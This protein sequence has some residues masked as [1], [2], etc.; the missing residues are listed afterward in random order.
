MIS[1]MARNLQRLFQYKH[2]TKLGRW[3]RSD[4]IDIK[5]ALANIDCCGDRLC[6]DA[7]MTKAAINDLQRRQK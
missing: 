4:N 5:A 7:L 6:G 3:S 1:K 2:T